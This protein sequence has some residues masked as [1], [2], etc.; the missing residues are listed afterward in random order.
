MKKRLSLG[1]CFILLTLFLT[2]CG[3]GRKYNQAVEELEN[4]NYESALEI[5]DEIPDYEDAENVREQAELGIIQDTALEY[6]IYLIENSGFHAPTSVRVLKAGYHSAKDGD[7]YA[8]FFESD[9]IFYFTIQA[10]T[11]GGG[12]ATGDYVI[13]HGGDKDKDIM[14][15][16]DPGNDYDSLK[17]LLDVG[18]LNN[19]ITDYWTELGITD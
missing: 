4:Q 18:K 8:S 16:D 10:T 13:L 2:G 19:G 17:N 6:M 11:K 3:N 5:L 12:S 9:G 7:E 1:I 14:S 15:N